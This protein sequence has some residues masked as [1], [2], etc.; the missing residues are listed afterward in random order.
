MKSINPC[1]IIFIV[2]L[3]NRS[4]ALESWTGNK[5]MMSSSSGKHFQNLRNDCVEDLEQR[6]ADC[7]SKHLLDVP[8]DLN[9][10]IKFLYLR[11]NNLTIL[12]NTSFLKYLQLTGL[13][14]EGNS[15]R[16]IESGAFYSLIN[17]RVLV[18][19][20]NANLEL[21][22]D[23]FQWSC[24]LSSLSLSDCGLSGFKFDPGLKDSNPQ[25]ATTGMDLDDLHS[26]S[27]DSC[28]YYALGSIHLTE[29]KIRTLTD[30]TIFIEWQFH[31][32]FLEGNPL[33][34][35]DPDAVAAIDVTYL[36]FGRYPLSLDVIKNITL[37]VEKSARITRLSI[38]YASITYI[39]PDLFDNFC[40]KTINFLDLQGNN[41]ILYPFVFASL[42]G[43]SIL[44]LQDC[45]LITIDPRYFEGMA[46][47]DVL[48]ATNNI[49]NSIN[50]NEFT[51]HVSLY[52]MELG[53]YQC[54]EIK[55]FAFKGLDDLTTLYLHHAYNSKNEPNFVIN[56][57]NLQEF[58]LVSS[59][60]AA[61][62]ILKPTLLT[63]RT[64]RL[65]VLHYERFD[66]IWSDF[67]VLELSKMAN[68][69][70]KV[71]FQAKLGMYEITL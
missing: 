49:I 55:K 5:E 38:V 14:L 45:N 44:I 26:K 27:V 6:S 19:S 33:H 51:W 58:K 57:E 35:V 12:R 63:L 60:T 65:K 69:I 10:D 7:S 66:H 42:N 56:H 43:V 11:D 3:L 70:E 32:L 37:G 8:Q 2:M 17:L 22:E 9:P 21:H 20:G 64:P 30:E 41:L 36:C 23:I 25:H 52:K 28:T 67:N 68:S 4:K 47:L 53:L 1:M 31:H 48:V 46:R 62:H 16:D 18:L 54:R 71:Y 40:N 24:A 13:N 34:R 59:G 15:I 61:R 29:N 39:P 50:P